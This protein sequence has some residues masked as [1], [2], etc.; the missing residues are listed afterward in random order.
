[1][2]GRRIE[3]RN[4]LLAR[5]GAVI[6]RRREPRPRAWWNWTVLGF[7]L[8]VLAASVPGSQ[9]GGRA[10]PESALAA[11]PRATLSGINPA[12]V[13]MFEDF[14]GA[15]TL[16]DPALDGSQSSVVSGIAFSG[17]RSLEMC[18]G[19]ACKF[20]YRMQLPEAVDRAYAR[21]MFMVG[22]HEAFYDS[23]GDPLTGEHYKNPGLE[24]GD[25]S[26]KGGGSHKDANCIAA[27]TRLNV[28]WAGMHLE[29]YVA[30][31]IEGDGA[32][33]VLEKS[34]NVVDGKWHCLEIMVK[35]NT[36]GQKDG[37]AKV[38]VDGRETALHGLDFR[39]DKT[40]QI[41]KY[42][43]T[44]WSNDHWKG[45]I[46]IDDVVVS[47]SR[48]GCPGAL[49]PEGS[50]Q[51]VPVSHW[52][53]AYIE[54]LY[55]GGYVAGCSEEPLLYCP[56]D[57]MTRAESAVF[58]ERGLWGGGYKPAEPGSSSFADVALD[59][60][61]VKWVEALYR[62]GFTAGCQVDPLRYCPLRVHT[63]AEAAV[64]FER[65]L[66]GAD[67][68]PPEP[69]A[70]HYEDVPVGGGAPWYSR[71]VYAA[72]ADGLVQACED[73]ANRGDARYRPLDEL[74]RAEAACMMALA[75]GIG[76]AQ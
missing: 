57:S 59:T 75:K 56:Q 16:A 40:W 10:G 45:P 17:S 46:Y 73:D 22:N 24:G 64:F 26:C 13:L 15:T 53:F 35:L 9:F 47:K 3:E 50:F 69:G 14:E 32:T 19:E 44:Y 48:I 27:R 55:R 8:A 37:E 1:M 20:S 65:M 28:P 38:W 2:A 66:H 60:W 5:R 62:D 71:W 30:Y 72:Y 18:A 68:E 31:G 7:A 43:W 52:A 42:W 25:S 58:V 76:G 33:S 12:D 61:Y 67:Y 70:A 4:H 51:D 39:K 49:A 6:L 74:S 63:R 11:E 21:Y 36:P 41:S 23:N 34:I 29:G 54:A